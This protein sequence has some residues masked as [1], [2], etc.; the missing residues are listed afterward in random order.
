MAHTAFRVRFIL[1]MLLLF[2]PSCDENGIANLSVEN[3]PDG[4]GLQRDL[5]LTTSER[6]ADSHFKL[7]FLHR[8]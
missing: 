2:L 6:G 1:G 7:R 5:E 4:P 8:R 3:L